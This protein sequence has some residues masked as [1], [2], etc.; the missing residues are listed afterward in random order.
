MGNFD[1][2]PS[3]PAVRAIMHSWRSP[4]SDEPMTREQFELAV[5]FAV[6]LNAKFMPTVKGL[7]K[8]GREQRRQAIEV[9]SRRLAD[10][11]L[12]SNLKPYSGPASPGTTGPSRVDR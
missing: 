1:T 9:Y 11:M 2:L 5:Y 12:T 3:T 10:H 7:E 4:M 8:L 6:L